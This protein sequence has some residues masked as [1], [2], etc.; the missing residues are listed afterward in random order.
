M[1]FALFP[2]IAII[3]CYYM[4][5][6]KNRISNPEKFKDVERSQV[7]GLIKESGLT[8]K[9][10]KWLLGESKYLT[11]LINVYVHDPDT[12]NLHSDLR[13]EPLLIL[14]TILESA[15]TLYKYQQE[16]NVALSK[17]AQA[18]GVKYDK[19]SDVPEKLQEISL[20]REGMKVKSHLS[21]EGKL[22]VGLMGSGASGKGT[23]GKRA[24]MPRAVNFTTRLKRPGEEHGVDYYYIREMEDG[25]LETL[26]IDT[27]YKVIG[28]DETAGKPIYE[29]DSKGNPV[30]YFGKHGPYV[31]TVHRPGRAKHGT[32]VIEFN[33]HFNNGAR[34]IFFEHGPIQ[35]A[36]AGEKL[37][38]FIDR[39]KV[40]PVCVLPP[41]TGIL[42]L[43][44]R[45]A[46]RTYGDPVHK[47]P[48]VSDS[49]KIADSYLESTIGSGQIE[50][51]LWTANFLNERPLGIVYI[52]NDNLSEAVAVLNNLISSN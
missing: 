48:A 6:N 46:V 21:N 30:D 9:V 8:S 37:P 51:F 38:G 20:K 25:L 36:E 7:E 28:T 14:N 19:L 35:V 29:K 5:D 4:I 16:Y 13:K 10:Q 31:T 24:G 11:N 44:I 45:I 27:G 17:I 23:M 34:S 42:P 32:S 3:A 18:N 39:A 22:V 47:D 43:A 50:E 1:W 33:R 26:D 12:F 15:D 49:Y 52:V 2:N 41:K 40:L